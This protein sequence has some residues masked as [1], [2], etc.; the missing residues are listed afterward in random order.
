MLVVRRAQRQDSHLAPNPGVRP[1]W[2][3]LSIRT[4]LL[5]Y[6]ALQA[7]GKQ[8]CLGYLPFITLALVQSTLTCPHLLPEQTACNYSRKLN[9]LARVP[10][11][12][13]VR[14][15]LR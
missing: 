13:R 9:S 8:N 1:K 5:V 11:L 12:I 2:L 6:R 4:A 15:T 14:L 7:Q 3:S 10:S